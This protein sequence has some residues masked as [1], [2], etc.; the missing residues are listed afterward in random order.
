LNVQNFI[1]VTILRDGVEYVHIVWTV[2]SFNFG[3]THHID[4]L[5]LSS[6]K[7]V[8]FSIES[9]FLFELPN[10]DNKFSIS[11][12]VLTS[13]VDVSFVLDECITAVL[14]ECLKPCVHSFESIKRSS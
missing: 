11:L 13:V 4:S 1:P 5:L 6:E 3:N 2:I 7:S 14:F 9:M 12:L 10:L 8:I